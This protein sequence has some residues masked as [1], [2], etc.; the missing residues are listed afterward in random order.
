[1]DPVQTLHEFVLNLMRYAHA[2]SLF[3]AD[4]TGTL[5]SA[6]LSGI[7]ALDVHE[8]LPLVMD[9]APTSVVESFERSLGS[10]G[11]Q[12]VGS[13]SNPMSA[14]DHL[15]HITENFSFLPGGSHALPDS[16]PA[17]PDTDFTASG[18]VT[19]TLDTVAGSVTG[20][21]GG[22]PV[23]GIGGGLP[24]IGDLPGLDSLPGLGELSGIAG[25]V[26]PTHLVE[27]GLPSLG[28]G[29]PGLGGLPVPGIG[30][31][32]PGI[33]DLPIPGMGHLPGLGD[34]PGTDM[35]VPAPVPGGAE[36]PAHGGLPG[37]GGLLDPGHLVGTVDSVGNITNVV[38][39]TH[40]GGIGGD[41]GGS[42]NVV[43]DTLG[44]ALGGGMAHPNDLGGIGG[45][46]G[47]SVNSV[48][49]TLGD[50][51]DHGAHP[52]HLLNHVT[53]TVGEA[54]H[55][56]NIGQD[57]HASGLGAVAVDA[58]NVHAEGII[59]IGDLTDGLGL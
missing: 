40:L 53:H 41:L 22:L 35:P 17:T 54:A 49:N 2:R 37:L 13:L 5:Q 59:S 52:E 15:Q 33:G 47:G 57:V 42:V 34:L 29:L 20:A 31:G 12:I 1:M 25:M 39:P 51:V 3:A 9:Y 11:D 43:T 8:V 6:G 44:G 21:V 30:G 7:T 55:D 18:D 56:L 4:P 50:A 45:D 32:L 38:G 10:T 48:T 24:G 46:L 27:G 23:P 28:G 36:D 19:H 16:G 58:G 26:D 14:I